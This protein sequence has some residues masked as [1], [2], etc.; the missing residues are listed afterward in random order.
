MIRDVQEPE[1]SL[2]P[3]D[4]EG[5]GDYEARWKELGMEVDGFDEQFT[6]A[7]KDF[8]E[9][10]G[11]DEAALAWMHEGIEK[12]GIRLPRAFV[13]SIYKQKING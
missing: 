5:E 3:G 2:A 7:R 9:S 1:L 12:R 6:L 10:L 4:P 13:M 8:V 11:G